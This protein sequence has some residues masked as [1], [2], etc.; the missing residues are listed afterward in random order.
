[1][2]VKDIGYFKL[3]CLLHAVFDSIET[4]NEWSDDGSLMARFVSH[5]LFVF[6]GKKLP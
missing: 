6:S 1:M 4:A 2:D 3:D 5:V